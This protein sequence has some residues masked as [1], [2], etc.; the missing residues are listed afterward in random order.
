MKEA[1]KKINVVPFPELR[2]DPVS[3]DWILISQKRSLRP[4]QFEGEEER[5][6]FPKKDCPF[7]DPQA[8][9][10]G[11]FM[12]RIPA[13]TRKEWTMQLIP[14]KYPAVSTYGKTS[15]EK[16]GP[17]QVAAAIGYHDVLITRDHFNNFPK[18]SPA[19][20]F[21][22]FKVFQ[23]RYLQVARDRRIAYVSIFHNWGPKAGASIFHPHYQIISI[24][25]I[26][27][28]VAHSLAGS[29]RFMKKNHRCVH[30]DLISFERKEKKRIIFEN[31][32]AV[33]FTPFVSREPLEFRVF[34]KKHLPYFE[35]TPDKEMKLVVQVLH[36]SLSLFEK[37]FR[38]V[39]YNFFIH[40][41]PI[42]NKRKY[43]HYH[44]H[45]EIQ[46]KI[47]ISAG[48]EL[49]TGIEITALD[50]N[51]AAMVIRGKKK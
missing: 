21:N 9:G 37:K 40:T 46:P 18:L 10:N 38:N 22:V 41:A 16:Y 29:T 5:E 32:S 4:D 45:I 11:P 47:N 23:E 48:F 39:D 34:P 14:N 27:S 7:E 43:G 44:W 35:D 28:D 3:G 50:P 8:S 51:E 31:E 13:D 49:S 20:A 6:I 17:Y 15:I 1:P 30:C 2:Q 24:P 25:V 36:K 19:D 12:I 26:P 33:A 42:K